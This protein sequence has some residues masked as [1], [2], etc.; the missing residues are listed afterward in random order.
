MTYRDHI[1]SNYTFVRT[2]Q[3]YNEFPAHFSSFELIWSWVQFFSFVSRHLVFYHIF[4]SSILSTSS[5]SNQ[6]LLTFSSFWVGN[7][8]FY[9][10]SITSIGIYSAHLV[11]VP[12]SWSSIDI[13]LFEYSLSLGF[14]SLFGQLINYI[15]IILFC[16]N[17][18]CDNLNQ[19]VQK[20]GCLTT[21]CLILT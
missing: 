15:I 21:I 1:S 5:F 14:L 4:L 16:F 3:A 11:S 18:K 6:G 17:I 8:F 20:Y 13:W 12:L 7:V 2:D 19:W 10:T 9:N